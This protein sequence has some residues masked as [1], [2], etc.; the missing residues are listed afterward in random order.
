MST[1]VSRKTWAPELLE[2]EHSL[3]ALREAFA[4]ST[5]GRGRLVLVSGEPGVG[6]TALLKRFCGEHLERFKIPVKVQIVDEPQFGDRFK[7]VRRSPQES[8]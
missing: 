5:A 7:K 8:K 2:R 1:V 3:E 4:E 6:K